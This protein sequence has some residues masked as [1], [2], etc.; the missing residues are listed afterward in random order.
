MLYRIALLFIL[1]VYC[2]AP[3]Q[4]Q[5]TFIPRYDVPVEEN[6]TNLEFPWV[7]GMNSCL[8]S[9]V[10]LD[11]DG[12][13]DLVVF[14]RTGA[15]LLTFRNNGTPNQVD[16]TYMSD[17]AGR[18]PPIEGWLLMHDYNC[19][20]KNDLFTY[21]QGRIKV[22]TNTSN[23]VDGVQFELD[24]PGLETYD[25]YFSNTTFI[26]T[27][28]S[29]VP[30][31]SDVDNDGDLD[32]LNVHFSW[33]SNSVAYYR[34][35]AMEDYGRCDTLV[36]DTR[37]HCWGFFTMNSL[38]NSI[39]LNDSC[40]FNVSNPEDWRDGIMSFL[41]YDHDAD[42]DKELLIGHDHFSN[43]TMASNG[44]TPLQ[45]GMDSQEQNFPQNSTPLWMTLYPVSSLMDVDN[46]GKKDLMVSPLYTGDSENFESV[47]RYKN[48]GI[49]AAY[50]FT[51]QGTQ[52][53]Q[54]D[55]IDVGGGSMPVLFDANADGLLDLIV[56]N[57][58][59]YQAGGPTDP[60]QMALYVNVGSANNPSFRLATRDYNQFSNFPQLGQ[61]L[62]PTFGDLDG[63][64]DEDMLVGNY[65]G[66]LYY[67]E[68]T[69][70]PNDSAEFVL[71]ISLLTDFDGTVINE[72]LY[73]KPLLYDLDEDQDLDL[74]IGAR[75]G[76]IHYYD[77]IGSTT[78]PSFRFR[79]DSLGGIN[80]A[81]WWSNQGYKPAGDF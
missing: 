31:L 16:Y 13:R 67:Y 7:G 54:E 48:D 21:G 27:N 55:M 45:S 17:L 24:Y 10:D 8:F 80:T 40:D 6:G 20:G 11:L 51:F 56:A 64:G 50:N 41:A 32:I 1:S 77:N 61:S 76:L 3:T 34:N 29:N 23:S 71:S 42:G 18:F 78:L 46:D 37:N 15:K 4:A 26:Y 63:D 79:T 9:E 49:G 62:S 74:L 35:L 60:S 68:N 69:A 52:F 25:D 30:A 14:E 22:Y 39:N 5:F 19:D 57:D 59:Y 65:D 28:A 58:D 43:L 81:L 2:V 66:N 33:T 75:D 72:G 53:L 70:L 12:I 47:W 38:S 36:F 44:G 73:A